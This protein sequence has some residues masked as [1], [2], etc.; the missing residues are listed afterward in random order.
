MILYVPEDFATYKAAEQDLGEG[1]DAFS[2]GMSAKQG[3]NIYQAVGRAEG[4]GA[5]KDQEVRKLGE[6]VGKARAATVGRVSSFQPRGYEN[7]TPDGRPFDN[8]AHSFSLLTAAE[9]LPPFI[10][11]EEYD[12]SRKDTI[13][14]NTFEGLRLHHLPALQLREQRQL[15]QPRVPQLSGEPTD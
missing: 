5:F 6:A 14:A 11:K 15:L 9:S 7:A 4:L 1:E 12:G 10:L 2:I 8:R 13:S 3:Y